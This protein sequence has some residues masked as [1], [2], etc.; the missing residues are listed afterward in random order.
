MSETEI[1][2]SNSCYQLLGHLT[3]QQLADISDLPANGYQ[4]WSAFND[5]N[6][7]SNKT[8]AFKTPTRGVSLYRIWYAND[9]NNT[10][11][12]QQ[13]SGLL[14]VPDNDALAP[15]KQRALPL[16]LFQHGT[17]FSRDT[18]PSNVVT[19]DSSG[20]PIKVNSA[21]TFFNI[22][23]LASSG[24][25]LL[26]A[27]YVGLANSK[28]PEG[29]IVKPVTLG[30]ING[31]LDSGR[32]V[33]ESLGLSPQ[34]LFLNGWSQG[35]V[36][37]Q[38]AVQ[39]Y[40]NLGVPVSAAA[41]QSPFNNLLDT[42][43]QWT[44]PQLPGDP[45]NGNWT[46]LTVAMFVYANAIW[47]G[48]PELFDALIKDEIVPGLN[49]DKITYREF[50]QDF[51]KDHSILDFTQ[52]TSQFWRVLILRNG[53]SKWSDV[54]VFT[55]Q[56]CLTEGVFSQQLNALVSDFLRTL[57]SDSPLNWK[58]KTP[59]RAWYGT[60]DEALAPRLVDPD[61]AIFGGTNVSL[62]PV[63][64]GDHRWNFLNSLYASADNIAGTD[65]NIISWF[66]S[67]LSPGKTSAQLTLE[68]QDIAVG[69]RKPI[70]I[71]LCRLRYRISRE[72]ILYLSA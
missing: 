71:Y 55:G 51:A 31:M 54:P 40:E 4:G 57:V 56:Q 1:V 64:N 44:T 46:P 30:A 16:V 29:Y 22:C 39:N 61:L 67:H 26:A 25:A 47:S 48:H 20:A 63:Q 70:Q 42:F 62:V 53:A 2:S 58:Y 12:N 7:L 28:I 6:H 24:Y 33:M 27:D 21:E 10:Y 3:A 66:N 8:L 41:I 13:V 15:T 72:A 9:T 50:L 45:A 34:Q 38:W 19:F 68:G 14:A 23:Q 37:T 36:N 59:L 69:K 18:V 32:L 11:G 65:Q 60:Q 17:T 49:P 5:P 35:A 43:K 52:S